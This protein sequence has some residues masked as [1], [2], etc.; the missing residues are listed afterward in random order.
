[1]MVKKPEPGDAQVADLIRAGARDYTTRAGEIA[2]GNAE[3]EQKISEYRR[4]LLERQN[5]S[6]PAPQ[7]P[8]QPEQS[9]PAQGRNRQRSRRNPADGEPAGEGESEE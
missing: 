8:E 7:Q 6:N 5:G 1:M 9:N 4:L 3:G 2:A